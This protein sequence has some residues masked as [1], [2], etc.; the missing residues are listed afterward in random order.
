ML[1]EVSAGGVAVGAEGEDQVV[2]AGDILQGI[3][4]DRAPFRATD[5]EIVRGAGIGVGAQIADQVA[6]GGDVGQP[7]EGDGATL[8][9]A[10]GDVVGGRRRVAARAEGGLEVAGGRPGTRSRRS[11]RCGLR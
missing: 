4:P 9:A 1:D 11:G 6:I 8:E 2:V 7:V 3:E 10:G 5:R